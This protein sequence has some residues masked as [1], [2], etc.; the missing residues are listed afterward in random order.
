MKNKLYKNLMIRCMKIII[1]SLN[2]LI[3][4]LMNNNIKINNKILKKK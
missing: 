1:I 2:N 4:Y 3:K